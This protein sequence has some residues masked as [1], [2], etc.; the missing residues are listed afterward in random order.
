MQFVWRESLKKKINNNCLQKLFCS[1]EYNL[2][3]E[4]KLKDAKAASTPRAK[5][6]KLKFNNIAFK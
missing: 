3:F 1:I 6:T 4:Q 5:V 2:C